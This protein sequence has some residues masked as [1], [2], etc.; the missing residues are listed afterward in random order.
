MKMS[1]KHF[2]DQLELA[3][4]ILYT[5]RAHD[6]K[7]QEVIG[8]DSQIITDWPGKIIEKIIINLAKEM[9]DSY[10]LDWFFWE[11]LCDPTESKSPMHMEIDGKEI[12]ATYDNIYKILTKGTI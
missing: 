2:K 8:P 12:P 5:S 11:V 7:L 6:D 3:K 1:K 4:E 10:I 9:N